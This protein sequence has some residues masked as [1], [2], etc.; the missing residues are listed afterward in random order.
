MPS[1]WVGKTLWP[2]RTADLGH[3]WAIR[4]LPGRSSKRWPKARAFGHR[5]E[6]RPGNLRIAHSWPKSA[7]RAGHNVFP[8][9]ELGI[10]HDPVRD[11]LRVFHDVGRMSDHARHEHP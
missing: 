10:A 2:A 9:H 7:V 5:F 6:L 11:H 3:E 8:T 4:R 1:S